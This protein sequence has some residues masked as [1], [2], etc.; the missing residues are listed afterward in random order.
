MENINEKLREIVR[1]KGLRKAAEELGIDH[2]QLYRSINSD[3]RLSTLQFILN[4]FGY[5]LRIIKRK[6]VRYKASKAST[7]EHN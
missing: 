2:G 5:D 6:E 1:E 4:R 3:L 7:L